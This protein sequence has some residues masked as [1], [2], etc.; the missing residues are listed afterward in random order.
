L[1]IFTGQT[2]P[3]EI[4]DPD[5]LTGPAPSRL[6][7]RRRVWAAAWCWRAEQDDFS[8]AVELAGEIIDPY[9]LAGPAPSRLLIRRRVWAA[10]WYWWGQGDDFSVAVELAGEIVEPF[11]AAGPAPTRPFVRWNRGALPGHP[12]QLGTGPLIL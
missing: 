8:I 6:L 10:A 12:N 2:P 3:Q 1:P 7:I 9:A 11:P 4:V 5:A